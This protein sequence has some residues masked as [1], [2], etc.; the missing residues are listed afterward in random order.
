M[1]HEK[2]YDEVL[3]KLVAAYKQVRIG[4][5]LTPGT[6][7]GPLHSA[8]AVDAFLAGVDEAQQ[9]GSKLVCG[10]TRAPG[11]A[12]GGNFVVPAILESRHDAPSACAGAGGVC[13]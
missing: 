3:P 7:C 12:P 9:Q 10:G 11:L 1:L 2:V 5:P 6:L 4:D 13:Y 8:A